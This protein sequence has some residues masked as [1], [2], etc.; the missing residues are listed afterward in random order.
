MLKFLWEEGAEN[1]RNALYFSKTRKKSSIRRSG[2]S[3]RIGFWYFQ[4]KFF[5][6]FSKFFKNY[7]FFL[8]AGIFLGGGRQ[9]MAEITIFSQNSKKKAPSGGHVIRE[10]TGFGIFMS[11]DHFLSN[12][13]SLLSCDGF[14][15][16]FLKIVLLFRS[17]EISFFCL[18]FVSSSWLATL[19]FQTTCGVSFLS[20]LR[21]LFS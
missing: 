15:L 4:V 9:K 18:C 17:L 13:N 12:F 2:Y 21:F 20:V 1:G 11:L 3:R 6:K 14:W 8:N 19:V 16:K 10:E 7:D 5:K